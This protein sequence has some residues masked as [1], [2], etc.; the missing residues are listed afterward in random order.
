MCHEKFTV[1]Y[2]RSQNR[3]PLEDFIETLE[4]GEIAKIN[5]LNAMLAKYGVSAGMPFVRKVCTGIW[6]LRARGKREIRLLFNQSD[7]RIIHLHVF[8]KKLIRYRRVI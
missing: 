1:S 5:R 4:K 8:I 3:S 7:A 6:E 2:F